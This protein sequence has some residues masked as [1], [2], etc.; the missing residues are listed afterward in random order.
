MTEKI[1]N[2]LVNLGFELEKLEDVGYGFQYEGI[3]YIW[4]PG[5]SDE[6][7]L[8][9]G[10]PTIMEKSDVDEATFYQLI[11]QVNSVLKY[12]KANTIGD[13]L[14]L[15]YERE[16]YDEHEDI[17]GII[18]RMIVCLEASLVM[19]RMLAQKV[20]GSMDDETEEDDDDNGSDDFVDDMED[21]NEERENIE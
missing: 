11:N 18:S 9:I 8:N 17:E 16:L 21:L 4:M 15:F 7:F 20:T 13:S 3:N 19:F 5:I 6:T 10:I 14:W 12:V 2:T 1:L